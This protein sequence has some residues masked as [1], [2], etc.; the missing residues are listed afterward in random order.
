MAGVTTAVTDS[1]LD[2]VAGYY[3]QDR[4]SQGSC[5]ERRLSSRAQR[6]ILVPRS[7]CDE[8]TSR[9]PEE[10]SD[11]GSAFGPTYGSEKEAAYISRGA[12]RTARS[13]APRPPLVA[14][15]QGSRVPALLR[16][17]PC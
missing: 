15:C 13:N 4:L 3:R 10:R 5:A 8:D 14:S 11:E 6:G 1:C 9:H 16:R 17:S 2:C 7:A 12:N